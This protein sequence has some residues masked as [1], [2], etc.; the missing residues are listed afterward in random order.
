[1]QKSLILAPDYW[2]D[3]ANLS[4]PCCIALSQT[5]R[6][7]L[8]AMN[9]LLSRLLHRRKYVKLNFAVIS[10]RQIPIREFGR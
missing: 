10:A 2:L 8:H 3:S 4:V 9:A 7:S 1:M 6:Q 5:P